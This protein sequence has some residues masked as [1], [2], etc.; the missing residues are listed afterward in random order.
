MLGAEAAR[1][2]RRGGRARRRRDAGAPRRAAAATT[3][4]LEVTGLSVGRRR[5]ASRSRSAPARCS[6]IAALEGQGQD[7]LFDV[8]AG[9]AVAAA[10]ARSASAGTPLKARHPY[11]AIRAGV[12]LVPADRL[13]ALLPQ[14]SV[15]ENIAAPRYNSVRRWGPI[16]MRDEGRRVR[17]A[18]STRCR[19]TR[20][21]RARCA[22]SPAAT[23]R[24]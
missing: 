16:N 4:A 8:L 18:R 5:R 19:S 21:R 12:V 15:R 23:S 6:A 24:R 2:D 11:D 7:E 9:A 13:H 3:S 20:A 17:D 14:R 10:A 1:R 22:G